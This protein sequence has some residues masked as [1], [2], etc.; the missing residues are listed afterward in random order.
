MV[1]QEELA[2]KKKQ[3][4]KRR[5]QQKT[6]KSA[7]RSASEDAENPTNIQASTVD[8][9]EQLFA[10]PAPGDNTASSALTTITTKIRHITA[11]ASI[12]MLDPTAHSVS[13]D[14]PRGYPLY[15]HLNS[16]GFYITPGIRFGGDYSVYP[17]D[18]FKFHAHFMATSY[19]WDEEITMLDLVSGGRLGTAVKK[20]FLIGGQAPAPPSTEL[21]EDKDSQGE[22]RAFT[23][24][25]AA[26]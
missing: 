12:D 4:E 15:A 20:G 22:V 25:W 21:E 14:T 17:G 11:T 6:K 9:N 19:E 24:E 7:S 10:Q 13:I 23:L 26:M 8:E 2:D 3:G 5:A 1:L 16:K 18:P